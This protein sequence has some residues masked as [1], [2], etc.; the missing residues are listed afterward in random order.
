MSDIQSD[1]FESSSH[2]YGPTGAQG[3]APTPANGEK[4]KEMLLT[5]PSTDENP[6]PDGLEKGSGE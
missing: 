4:L 3:N 2:H 5:A 1:G 6:G